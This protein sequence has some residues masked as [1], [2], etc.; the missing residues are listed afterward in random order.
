MTTRVT[1]DAHAGWPVLV[2]LKYGEAQYPKSYVTERVEPFTVR[3]FY[4]HSGLSLVDVQECTE[5]PSK[6]TE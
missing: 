4:L 5:S 1:V 3:D 6:N 2:V